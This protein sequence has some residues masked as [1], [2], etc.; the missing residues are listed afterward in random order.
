MYRIKNA[1]LKSEAG[2]HTF[3]ISATIILSLVL[4][5]AGALWA[6][7][8]QDADKTPAT[9]GKE[10]NEGQQKPAAT[11]QT[12]P[13][14]PSETVVV[15]APRI[16][17]PLNETPA[18]TTV[19][20][21]DT[22]NAMPRGIGAEEA[23]RLVPGVKVDNQADGE[24]VHLSIRGQGLLTE[25]GIRGI[26]VLL[27][28]LPLNDPT[29]FAP[30]LFDVD[31]DNVNRMEVFRGPASALYGGGSAGGVINI[32]TRDGG[33][34]PTIGDAY[35]TAGKYDFYK[36]FSQIGGNS[37][38][39]NYMITASN[40]AGDGYRVHTAFRALNLY[41]KFSWK[42][43]N[44]GKLTAIVAGTNFFNENAEGL[45]PSQ[46]NNPRQPNPDA[47]TFNEYQRTR[48]ITAGFTGQFHVTS[49]QDFSFSV[50]YRNTEWRES[51]PSSV[52]HSTYNTPGAIVQY[53]F[54]SG[55][56]NVKNHLTIGS[57]T[58]WQTIWDY[59]NANLGG[60]KEGSKLSDSDISQRGT[61]LY[62]LDRIEF[63]AR[64]NLMFDLRYDNIRNQLTDNFNTGTSSLSGAADFHQTT[65]R[66]GLSY[67][68]RSNF[69]IYMSV[70]Q[71][72][73]P[74]STNELSNNPNGYGG[75]NMSLKPATSVGEEI[76]IRGSAQKRF[77]YDVAFFHLGT[78]DDF[79]RYRVPTRP[80]E[81]FYN[82]IA[83]SR[84]YGLESSFSWFPVDPLAV[85]VAYTYSDFKY[86][87]VQSL[88]GT[89]QDVWM[90]NSPRHQ[91]Y[92]DLEYTVHKGL[93]VGL[94]SDMV[95]RAYVDQT[96]TLYAWG[97]A[98][99]N[100]RVGYR[101]NNDKIGG[102]L[103]VSGRNAGGKYYIAFTEPDPDRNS[104]QPGPTDEW[105]VTLRPF[106]GG[107][108]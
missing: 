45:N 98:L 108:R 11:T 27:D 59:R 29:G 62:A 53:T 96:N 43:G 66:V 101:W 81:T 25:R 37:G 24:R 48:R 44:N 76:G 56:G 55:Q 14:G 23:F 2:F 10:S 91:A 74:P 71:G 50:Y 67:D 79:G 78:K 99:I 33:S 82:N 38:A 19:V 28:G 57:D 93:F 69:G 68:P 86:T 83:D 32:E 70:G 63:G 64:V 75:F 77:F 85:R 65:G 84:R 54:H 39:T 47:L 21:P 8:Q 51:V 72:F 90:P 9:A 58:D 97:Y 103:M 73:L 95:S 30:D 34:K 61:G 80:L 94:G 16:E 100:P 15:T 7:P 26:K 12:V 41:S 18:A 36:I 88:W 106:F 22:L 35:I 42:V 102:E 4:I 52:Q 40:T 3:I 89:F 87:N 49:S 31:W 92:V 104:F 5:N 1:A 105:F 6:M 13:R 60:A 20:S 46:L 17:I 107:Q